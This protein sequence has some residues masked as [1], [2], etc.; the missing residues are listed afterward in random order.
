M[1]AYIQ[2][3]T[4]VYLYIHIYLYDMNACARV[5]TRVLTTGL[6]VAG[7]PVAGVPVTDVPTTGPHVFRCIHAVRDIHS[8]F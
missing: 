1:H 6:P 2:I 3:H 8:V 7:M 5:L 4:Y